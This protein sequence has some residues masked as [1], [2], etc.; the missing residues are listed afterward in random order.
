M[1]KSPA[2]RFWTKVEKTDECWLW[3]GAT[4]D[5]GYGVVR[6]GSGPS[7][8]MARAHRASYEMAYGPIPDGRMV[9]HRCDNPPCVRPDHLFLGDCADNLG[10]MARKLRVTHAKLDPEKVRE[11]RALA[12]DG[13]SHPRISERFGINVTSVRRVVIRRNWKHVS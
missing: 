9:C 5:S 6:V 7:R 10:D 4:N 2:D 8:R 12:A 13:W 1:T 3:T 11:I